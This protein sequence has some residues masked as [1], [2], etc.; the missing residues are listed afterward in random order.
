MPTEILL[1]GFTKAHGEPASSPSNRPG[2]ASLLDSVDD[3]DAFGKIDAA[4]KGQFAGNTS[5]TK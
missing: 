5:N 4:Q 2:N 3:I 1:P